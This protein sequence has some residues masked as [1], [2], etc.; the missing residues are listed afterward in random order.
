LEESEGVKLFIWGQGKELF[1][2]ELN[3][4]EAMRIC[5]EIMDKLIQSGDSQTIERFK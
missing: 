4:R 5:S 1:S 2:A 3:K